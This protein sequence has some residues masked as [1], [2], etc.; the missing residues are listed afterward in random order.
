MPDIII[1]PVVVPAKP[2]K[3]FSKG[4]MQKMIV[5]CEGPNKPIKVSYVLKPY[6]GDS[7]VLNQDIVRIIEDARELL[8]NAPMLAEAYNA[9]I[10]AV[11]E[12]EASI[13]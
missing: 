12:H 8:P 9:I 4:W 5:T 3:T 7:E 1:S 2:E 13:S 10:N 11:T 6:D